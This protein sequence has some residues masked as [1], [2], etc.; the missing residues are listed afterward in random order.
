MAQLDK[1]NFMVD[2]Y[3][4]PKVCS[5]TRTDS[6]RLYID[7]E[8]DGEDS[9]VSDKKWISPATAIMENEKMHLKGIHGFQV[10]K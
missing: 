8:K 5:P 9:S 2:G 10:Q 6:C 4:Y 1:C 3:H 7:T